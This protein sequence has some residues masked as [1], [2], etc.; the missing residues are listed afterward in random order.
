[1][2]YP[3]IVTDP[4]PRLEPRRSTATLDYLTIGTAFRPRISM[5]G[6]DEVHDLPPQ[7]D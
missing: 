2:A 7:V 6:W 4:K 5:Q 1:M 3:Y